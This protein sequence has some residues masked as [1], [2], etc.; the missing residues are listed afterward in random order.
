[1]AGAWGS[2][3][4]LLAILV[5]LMALSN[6]AGKKTFIRVD[7]VPATDAYAAD[8]LAFVTTEYN[9]KS[10]DKYNFR[11]V[12][13]L[14][15]KKQITDHMEFHMDI[16]MRRTTCPKLEATNCAF[17]EGELYKETEAWRRWTTLD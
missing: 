11:I 8:T 15:I 10:E 13:A 3:W 4:F 14:K 12:R 17:Q 1:M 16:E 9:K 5:A 2:P 6:E 7:E